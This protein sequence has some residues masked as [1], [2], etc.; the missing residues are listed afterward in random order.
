MSFA[1]T[2]GAIAAVSAGYSVYSGIKQRNRAK[3]LREQ[4]NDP[5]I[6]QNYA[7]DR[8]TNTLF[9]NYSNYNLPGYNN[10]VQQVNANMASSNNLATMASTSSGDVLNAITMNQQ[11]AN[12]SLG[13]LAF[14][15]ANGREQAL[16]NYLNAVQQQ[17]NDQLRVNSQQLNRYERTLNEAAALEGAGNTNVNN[18]IQDALVGVQAVGGSFAPRQ[19]IDQ[20]T[21][22]VVNLPS[23]WDT[24]RNKRRNTRNINASLN[25]GGI[26]A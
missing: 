21:G 9:Q 1:I 19:S 5:G 7:L 18:G 11:S 24:Y 10:Y 16:M 8:V 23:V 3:N 14:Q 17:G 26:I 20:A 13:E 2:T 12:N 22:Q 4:A 6:Q 15:N 25:Q